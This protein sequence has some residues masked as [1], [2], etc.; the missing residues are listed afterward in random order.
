MSEKEILEAEEWH[1]DACKKCSRPVYVNQEGVCFGCQSGAAAHEETRARTALDEGLAVLNCGCG[2]VHLADSD[3]EDSGCSV[4]G[5]TKW[6]EA[7]QE[8]SGKPTFNPEESAA[9]F[10]KDDMQEDRGLPTYRDLVVAECAMKWLVNFLKDGDYEAVPRTDGPERPIRAA[11]PGAPEPVAWRYRPSPHEEWRPS[12]TDPDTWF[13]YGI[14][15]PGEVQP[16]Y[17]GAPAATPEA[18][19]LDYSELEARCHFKVDWPA[20]EVTEDMV[21]RARKTINVVVPYPVTHRVVELA[22]RAA[23]EGGEKP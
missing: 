10:W 20:P 22:L 2:H 5:C 17:L 13:P 14:K 21:E 18:D 15:Y 4:C 19:D 7:A 1:K 6:H 11:R 23:L 3:Q 16:L 12:N 8:E 9:Q